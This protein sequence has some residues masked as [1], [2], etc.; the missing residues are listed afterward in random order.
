MNFEKPLRF[1]V[2]LMRLLGVMFVILYRYRQRQH[3]REK[4]SVNHG[5]RNKFFSL[6]I[7]IRVFNFDGLAKSPGIIFF[8]LN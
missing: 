1:C 3:L 8:T 7:F 4:H 6:S 5:F 2:P